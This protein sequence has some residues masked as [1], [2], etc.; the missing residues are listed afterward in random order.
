[1]KF[2]S[3]VLTGG[4]SSRMGA[5]KAFLKIGEKTFIE[6]AAEILQPNCGRVKAVF[7]KSQNHL[8]EKLPR[9]VLPIFDVYENRGALGGI[10]A[11]L[12]DCQTEFALVLA[13]DLPLVTSEAIQKLREIIS[14]EK[15]FA[16]VVPRQT[17]G[18]L[19]P[20]CAVYGVKDCLKKAEEILSKTESASMRHFLETINTKIIDAKN[21]SENENLFVNV[22]SPTDFENISKKS[23]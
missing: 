7:N 17:D 5:D 20:L 18:K 13:V 12:Q 2:T 16:A 8:I 19:Q 14:N 21:L 4:K 9:N 15:D 6:N 1:M 11:A 23:V 10:H 3:Y 22:N